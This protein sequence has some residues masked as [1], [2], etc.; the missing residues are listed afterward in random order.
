MRA[1]GLAV[2]GSSAS[3][4]ET[5]RGC[6][7]AGAG[8]SPWAILGQAQNRSPRRSCLYNICRRPFG[9]NNP[10]SAG[11]ATASRGVAASFLLFLAR[12]PSCLFGPSL[13]ATRF[14]AACSFQCLL[15]P[16]YRAA[17]RGPSP[18]VVAQAL[19]PECRPSPAPGSPAT[20]QPRGVL[21][22]HSLS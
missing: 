14:R 17:Q 2:E 12:L 7:E 10:G 6:R 3:T 16:S 20:L 22:A 18:E 19:C 5:F 15:L 11:Q 9:E 4:L 1:A 8:A 21:P 13:G